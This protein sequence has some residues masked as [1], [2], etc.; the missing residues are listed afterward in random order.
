M[1]QIDVVT[2]NEKL[3]E[4]ADA[5][6]VG[7]G[8]IGISTALELADRGLS[9][10]VVEKGEVACEQSSRNW[11]WCRQMGRDPRE[12]P[13][14]QVALAKW[15]NMNQRVGA[16]T[17]FRQ[18][19]I[20]YLSE[21]DQQLADREEWHR[22]VAVPY[23]LKTKL[24][25]AKEA[26]AM[27]P[28][29]LRAWA[30]GLH[31]AEDGRAEPFIAVPA[32]ARAL[33]NSSG[34]VF[35]QCAARG[36]ELSGGKISSLVTEKGVIKTDTVIVAGGYWTRRFLGNLKV[37]FP[38]TGVVNSVLRTQARDTG[39]NHTFSGYKYAVRKRLDG[40]FTVTHNKYSL[41]DLTP[42]HFSQFFRF[43]PLLQVDSKGVKLRLGRRFFQELAM[44]TRW[45]LDQVT[46]FELVRVLDP[47]PVN[48][49]LNDALNALQN[50][51]PAFQGLASVDRW[52]GMID[53]TPDA[54]P[55]ID[56]I[57]K[58]PG[59]FVASG[60]SGH[61]FGLGPGAGQLM[62]EIVTGDRPCVDP[63]PFR[64]ARFRDGSKPMPSTG[65]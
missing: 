29:C 48:S 30:G 9:V 35:T 40:G 1:P 32:M 27:V 4:R 22:E 25:G 21:S 12:V 2:P 36:V 60:F 31:T 24:L 52:A 3:P 59:L 14:I 26:Q 15:R 11:G 17:G 8:V 37:D 61:G 7:A 28:G 51:F 65:L 53:A 6:V 19:G 16:E 33:Q 38:Q 64:L 47:A 50:D 42:G 20:V 10:A 5:V 44:K 58:I 13:L 49:I 46:P 56:Q 62:A 63:K 39:I 34:M 45:R 43:L 57:E 23:K 18:C 54:V 55:V 41:A